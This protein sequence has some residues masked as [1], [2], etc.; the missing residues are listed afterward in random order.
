MG[1]RRAG[2]VGIHMAFVGADW[3]FVGSNFLV[4]RFSDANR[5]TSF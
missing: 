2:G 5:P 1:Q 3:D 4:E